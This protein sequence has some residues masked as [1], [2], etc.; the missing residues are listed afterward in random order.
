MDPRIKRLYWQLTALLLVAHFAGWAHA[1]PLAIALTA[2]QAAHVALFRRTLWTLDVQVR[3]AYTGLLMLG[4]VAP[5][6]PIHVVQLIGVNALLVCEYCLLAR[7][8]VLMPWN[9]NEP[10]TALLIRRALLT[11]PASQAIHRLL[12][13]RVARNLG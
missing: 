13:L 10:L 3:I 8:L 12:N 2:W 5:L 4:S 9:R 1:M 11:P 7:L 6:W